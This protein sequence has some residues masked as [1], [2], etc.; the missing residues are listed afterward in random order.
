MEMVVRLG[1][2]FGGLA[3][4]CRAAGTADTE[5][6]VRFRA[7]QLRETLTGAWTV[8]HQGWAGAQ[9]GCRLIARFVA[10][11]EPL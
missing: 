11:C 6:R 2:Y 10:G 7:A 5:E 1:L 9:A 8:L 3:L 4:G